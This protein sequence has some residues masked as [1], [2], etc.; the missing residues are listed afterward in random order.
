MPMPVSATLISTCE[1]TR[2]STTCTLPP[3]G[4]NLIAFDSRFQ[5]TCCR[6]S[7]RRRSGRPAGRGTVASR[8]SFASADGRTV[9]IAA[10][11]NDARVDR[12]DVEAHLARGDPAHVE[13]VVDE[14]GLHARVALDGLEAASVVRR[15]PS[16]P[17]RRTC[18][19]P[20]I[21][22][23]GVRSSCESVARNSSFIS[24]MRSASVRAARSLS[25]SASRSSAARLRRFV[26]AG[27]VDGDRRPARRCRRPGA[28]RAR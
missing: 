24:L 12:L 22:L 16:A 15:G 28:R 25:S 4:V 27:V 5:T 21:A 2:S 20:R 19:Q 18:D 7:G 23:S 17:R 3:L 14:L 11:M 9:S 10:S 26:E 13:Q 1:F 6:R 8:M